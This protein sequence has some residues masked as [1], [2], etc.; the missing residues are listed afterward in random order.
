MGRKYSII[1]YKYAFCRKKG[2][3][4]PMQRKYSVLLKK[5]SDDFSLEKLF[6]P[7][8]FESINVES[9]DVNRPGLQLAGFYEYFDASRMQIMGNAEIAYL[10]ECPGDERH[11]RI[12]RFFSEKPVAVVIT[13]N[14][15]YVEEIVDGAKKFGVPIFRTEEQTSAFVA[16]LIAYL[17]VELAPRITRHGVLVEVYG[18]GMLILGESGVG[19]SET[20]IELIKRGHRLIADDAVLIKKVS[21]KTLVGEAPENI[22]HFVELRGI[23]IVNARRIFGMGAIKMTEKI[24]MVVK[25][26]L[27]DSNKVYDR[28]GIDD[29][30]TEILGINVPSLTIPVKPG[31]NLAIKLEV[32]AMNNRQKKMGYNAAQELM[33]SI[34][35]TVE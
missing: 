8:N 20:A 18:E 34:G 2:G 32:A 21:G 12:D 26:E 15:Q 29:E 25:M 27:W 4:K 7:E 14:I 17:S 11:E 1:N 35:M 23:G 3:I 16:A 33:D 22:R 13:R 19:K 5:L 31:R 28:M 24:D 30:T 10:L 6:V 9:F